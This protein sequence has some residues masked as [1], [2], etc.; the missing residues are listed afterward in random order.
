[1]AFFAIFGLKVAVRKDWIAAIL[2]ALLF[3]FSEGDVVNSRELLLMVAIYV[4]LYAILIFV[5]LRFGLLSMI[6]AIYFLN[7]FN[8]ITMGADWRAWYVPF[9]VASM[10]LMFAIAAFAFWRSI[11]DTELLAS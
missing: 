6:A 10:L 3:T 5:L 9:A 4:S 11:G 1:M 2:A 8:A 7:S